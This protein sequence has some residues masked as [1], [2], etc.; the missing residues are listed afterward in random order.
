MIDN[1]ASVLIQPV[2]DITHITFT[3]ISFWEV[4]S[5]VSVDW[6]KLKKIY[7]QSNVNSAAIFTFEGLCYQMWMRLDH[8]FPAQGLHDVRDV[9]SVDELDGLKDFP[10]ISTNCPAEREVT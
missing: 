8:F 6:P 9:P 1:I 10:T 2:L 4:P 3:S 5:E 7:C